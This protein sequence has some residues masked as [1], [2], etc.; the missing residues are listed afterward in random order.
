MYICINLLN[1]LILNMQ[2]YCCKS[3]NISA[4]S[5]LR[6]FAHLEV[7]FH[8]NCCDVERHQ[9]KNIKMQMLGAWWLLYLHPFGKLQNAFLMLFLMSFS[10]LVLR[11]FS[12]PFS[13]RLLHYSV[14]QACYSG[15]HWFYIICSS[16]PWQNLQHTP[17]EMVYFEFS[18]ETQSKTYNLRP[19]KIHFFMQMKT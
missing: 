8:Y 4:F 15:C 17:L 16:G 5:S 10:V 11:I 14:L 12:Q 9:Y 19:V 3:E 2:L 7:C 13:R 6:I 18:T 1:L